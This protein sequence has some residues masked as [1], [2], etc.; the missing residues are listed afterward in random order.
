MN[1]REPVLLR[2]FL[3]AAMAFCLSTAT[4]LAH[5]FGDDYGD[6]PLATNTRAIKVGSNYAARIE[7]DTDQDWFSFVAQPLQRYTVSVST[8]SLWHS[9]LV[10]V[11][12]D[13]VSPIA[14][15]D[16]V[17]VA[18]SR[19]SW[20]HFGP[21]TTYYIGIGGFAQF[22]TGTYSVAVN[23]SAFKDL[24]LDGM[25]DDWEMAWFGSTNQA[26]S[27]D[28]DHDG[29]NNLAEFRAGTSPVSPQ[30]I[31]N[32]QGMTLLSGVTWV[33]Y[34]VVPYRC[35][36]LN[37]CTN[38]AVGEWHPLDVVTNFNFAGTVQFP[39]TFLP[40]STPRFYRLEVVF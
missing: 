24:D 15:T 13:A 34:D 29:M 40:A 32:A 25:D 12:P 37:V 10:I 14:S 6:Q 11:A 4:C 31:L 38:L 17:A 26:A 8:G 23:S 28:F 5:D 30:S 18:T 22:T 35:Y 36:R 3:A 9:T 20:V 16:S 2:L 27:G 33:A 21:P 7:I 19:V 39:D 1:T